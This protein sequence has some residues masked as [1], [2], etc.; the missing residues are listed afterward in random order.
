MA[1][2]QYEKYQPYLDFIKEFAASSNAAT[3]SKVDANANVECKNVTTLTGELYKKEGIG[4]NR[5]RMWQKIKEMYG[6]EYA[7]K[8]IYQLDHHFIYRHDETNPC[9]PYCVS[10]TMY[11]FLFNGLESI[12]GGSSAPH[13]LDSFCGEFINLC[14]AIASQF[15]GAVATPEFIPLRMSAY[16]LQIDPSTIMLDGF[17]LA[18]W[19]HDIKE[20]RAVEQTRKQAAELKAAET[21][22]NSLLSADKKTELELDKFAALLDD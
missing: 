18:D 2:E 1:I 19:M 12:G 20:L 21:R 9:L 11:P 22:L 5:L 8:Y 4:I 10:I 6:Q 7:D 17:Y 15:A 16:D 14:F 3:G 13:N